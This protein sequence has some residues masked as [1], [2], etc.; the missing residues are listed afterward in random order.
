MKIAIFHCEEIPTL[1]LLE[2]AAKKAG[3]ETFVFHFQDIRLSLD[4]GNIDVKVGDVSLKDFSII[5]CR[6]FW[7]YQNEVAVLAQFCRAHK[8]NLFDSALLTRHTI[9]KMY[10]LVCFERAGLPV[11]KTIFSDQMSA[12]FIENELKFPLVAKEDR[13]RQGKNVY[14]LK[15]NKE[16][17][18]FIKKNSVDQKTL[19][20]PT[21]QFQEFIPA[22]FDVRVIVIG[23]KVIGA[24]K[25]QSR[26]P[27]EFRHNISLGGTATEIK[28]SEEMERMAILAAKSLNFE[29]GGADFITN[30]LTGE[31]FMLEVNRSPG[32]EGFM[33]ATGIDVPMKLMQFFL[34]FS[35]KHLQ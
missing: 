29:F 28:I 27:S 20:T 19:D 34:P 2:N 10:D 5:F 14:L 31:I 7:N 25:R 8:I 21:Y 33:T 24:I 35:T 9:S 15:D 17:N 30:K 32:F 11:P 13:S 4:N 1:F 6:G 26:D 16:L 12:G 18:D 3:F 22:E 23:G